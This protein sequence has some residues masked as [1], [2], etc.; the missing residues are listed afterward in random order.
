MTTLKNLID[1]IT[2]EKVGGT[3]TV[4]TMQPCDRRVL[5][6][7]LKTLR[8]LDARPSP[9]RLLVQY[10]ED[11]T[12]DFVHVSGVNGELNEVGDEEHWALYFTRWEEWL[13]MAVV[14][15]CLQQ[16]EAAE[17][18]AACLHVMSWDGE[19]QAQVR[20]KLRSISRRHRVFL[21]HSSEDKDT[22]A[23]PLARE[24][25][26]LGLDI[27]F[28]E[29]ELVAGDSLR[30]SIAAGISESAC[31]IVV[32][33]P[34]FFR[35]AWTERE[36]AGIVSIETSKRIPLIPVWHD[37]TFKEVAAYDPSLADRVALSTRLLSIQEIA[38]RINEAVRMRTS[39]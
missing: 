16:F 25:E 31:A 28:D 5:R 35:K 27:W 38:T 14:A 13:G 2:W 8:H 10:T 6:N 29:Y 32:L 12:G 18:V 7:V 22:V 9:I 19:S 17:I 34:S 4:R 20:A 3:L 37:V 11:D 36:L 26:D 21:S 39:A 33:S 24:L 1:S 15:D 23:R 30:K